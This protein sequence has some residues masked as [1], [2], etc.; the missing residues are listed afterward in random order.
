MISA[1]KRGNILLTA[2]VAAV[3]SVSG[4]GR[5]Q[6]Q[7]GFGGGGLGFGFWGGNLIPYV[8][9]PGNYL[10]QVS[11]AQIAR[12]PSSHPMSNGSH[13]YYAGNPNS[14]INHVRDNGFVDRYYP[15]RREPS[16]YG[17]SARP[18]AQRMTPTAGA[19]GRTRPMVPLP[20]FYNAQNQLIWPGDSPTAGD[21]KEKRG[22]FDKASLT[23]LDE[24]KQNGVASIASVT[25]ARQKLLD[26]GR[27]ALKYVREHE[28]PRV[29]DSF[30]IFL[31]SL[32]DS[33]AQAAGGL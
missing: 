11:L 24:A 15:D 28:T 13:M 2:V 31:L 6:A 7:G 27:P 3:A 16:Y 33:L 30:H 18:P 14:Y 9:Q 12:G 8:Q 21:L 29:A 26:Y 32:Y 10:N 5:A 1:A 17:Y 20:S 4:A 19:A 23:V 25:E 22:A